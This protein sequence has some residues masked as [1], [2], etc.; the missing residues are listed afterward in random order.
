[1]GHLGASG[2][3]GFKKITL[4]AD[5]LEMTP[6]PVAIFDLDYTLLEGDSEVIWSQFLF[7]KG[8]A[9]KE[10]LERNQEY[11]RDYEDGELNFIESEEFLLQ[12]LTRHPLETLLQFRSEFLERIRPI[13]RP[14]MLERVHWHRIQG[15]IVLLITA[16]NAF[17]SEP[18]AALLQFE[19]FI[20]T[21]VK[22][23]GEAYTNQIEGIPAHGAGKVRLLEQWLSSHGLTL[24]G[25]WGYSDSHNDLP[26]LQRVAN[27][28]AVTPD[29][30]L[31]AYALEQGWKIIQASDF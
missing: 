19:N 14:G 8:L 3:P 6:P 15:H 7:E 5:D 10:W 18:I 27:P 4:G 24:E 9:G 12:P 17:I 1:M 30:R 31:R 2:D 21:R 29:D 23:L 26:L 25:S 28:V 11:Y 16:T 22:R 13:I 20:C